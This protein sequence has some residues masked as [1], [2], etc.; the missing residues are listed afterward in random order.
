MYHAW[1]DLELVIRVFQ[2]EQC[3]FPGY[4]KR[5]GEHIYLEISNLLLYAEFDKSAAVVFRPSN[6][7]LTKR[8]HPE[9]SVLCFTTVIS[10]QLAIEMKI[11]WLYLFAFHASTALR[12]PVTYRS[13]QGRIQEFQ[14]ERVQLW[15]NILLTVR[16]LLR[17]ETPSPA[18]SQWKQDISF[19]CL[20]TQ[21]VYM[22]LI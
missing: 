8:T 10:G 19:Q 3:H 20:W 5:E 22:I 14:K 21:G 11:C 1:K 9:F 6:N 18:L 2:E 12:I 17:C 15:Q 7:Y 4:H 13:D 16:K